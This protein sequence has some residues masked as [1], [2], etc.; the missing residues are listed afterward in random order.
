[1]TNYWMATRTSA[2]VPKS[3]SKLATGVFSA[4][5]FAAT[6]ARIDDCHVSL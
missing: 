5:A 4:D 6:A 1:M 3:S 2:N